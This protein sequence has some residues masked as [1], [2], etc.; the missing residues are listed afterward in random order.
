MIPLLRQLP[1]L[2][3]VINNNKKRLLALRALLA[4]DC[5]IH[6][7]LKKRPHLYAAAAAAFREAEA[8]SL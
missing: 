1:S 6:A 2:S 4:T 8:V 7:N 5:T 3:I